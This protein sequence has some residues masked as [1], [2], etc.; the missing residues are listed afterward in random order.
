MATNVANN[1]KGLGS[2]VTI[3]T[4]KI[5]PKK[6]RFFD[7]NYSY[8]LLRVDTDCHIDQVKL[9][10][11]ISDLEKY[12]AI[13]VSDYDKGFLKISDIIAIIQMAKCPVF[14]DTKKSDLSMFDYENVFI[15]IN[16]VESNIALT[17]NL[18]KAKL[19]VT[20]GDRGAIFDG[21]VFPA[22]KSPVFDVCG[23][24][25]TFL[26]ALAFAMTIEND[27]STAIYF[28][29]KCAAV[30]VQHVGTYAI[31]LSDIGA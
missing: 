24:G 5:K 7:M 23:A 10:D 1:L 27:V 19:I 13:V 9:D 15:K 22:C 4:N 8:Q 25:D 16:E 29:N 30:A 20:L 6:E 2:D 21:K 12:D 18:K 3:V 28:A 17:T 11:D 14:I 31:K 26:A